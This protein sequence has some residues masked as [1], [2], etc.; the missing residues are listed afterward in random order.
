MS[1]DPSHGCSCL[2]VSHEACVTG[3]ASVD[4][5]LGYLPRGFYQ[6]YE[7]AP[8]SVTCPV[9]SIR[10]MKAPA[11]SVHAAIVPSAT[12]GLAVS[13]PKY[14]HR[15]L[16]PCANRYRRAFGVLATAP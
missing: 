10:A 7:G 5:W 13:A 12:L 1:K 16:P 3:L 9:V 4:P 8:G 6:S 2:Q 15:L 14:A 11:V